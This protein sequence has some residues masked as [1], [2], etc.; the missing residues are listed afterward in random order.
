VA[1]GQDAIGLVTGDTS[2]VLAQATHKVERMADSLLAGRNEGA[3]A[4]LTQPDTRVVLA[5]WWAGFEETWG[6]LQRAHV[7]GSIRSGANIATQLVLHH[8]R[9]TQHVR[10]VA[11]SAGTLQQLDPD[12]V[13]PFAFVMP[14]ALEPDGTLRAEDPFTG[15][16]V[17]F[18]V[19]DARLRFLGPG[20]EVRESQPST[21]HAGWRPGGGNEH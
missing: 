1:D 21:G 14:V 19:I 2:I 11:D 4:E 15:E 16:F 5:Q 18:R 17:R 6:P 13:S 3:F 7:T 10:L 20:A 12:R 8:E 9:A